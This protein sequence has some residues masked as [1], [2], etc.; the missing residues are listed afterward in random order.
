MKVANSLIESLLAMHPPE[1]VMN[2]KRLGSL[3]Q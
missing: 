1:Q 3:H 2:L